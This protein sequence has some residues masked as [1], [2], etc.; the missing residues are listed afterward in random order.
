MSLLP[1]NSTPLERDLETVSSRL[2]NVP[3]NIRD[4]WNPDTCPVDL[5][6]WLAWSMSLDSW[7][8]YWPEHVKRARI[9]NAVEIQRRKGTRGSVRKVVESFGA[10]LEFQEWFEQ[11]PMG[12]PH[13]FNVYLNVNQLGAQ[14]AEFT[15]DIVNEISRVKSARSYFEV[16][17]GVTATSQMGIQGGVRIAKFVRAKVTDQ[18]VMS[19]Q[20]Q[21][22][23][24]GAVR[25]FKHLQILSE[26][27]EPLPS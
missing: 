1:P 12:A 6:P 2:S 3:V 22:G 24:G 25:L 11:T 15:T 8:S 14:T 9:K 13:S 21:L 4:T 23:L 10:E 5:L 19:Y 17:Q 27:A 18:P 26:A 7:K 20:G 16:R